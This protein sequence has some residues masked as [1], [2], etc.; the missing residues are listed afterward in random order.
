MEKL[1]AGVAVAAGVTAG[2]MTLGSESS[3]LSPLRKA[4]EKAIPGAFKWLNAE[5]KR[6]LWVLGAG[7]AVGIAGLLFLTPY[8]VVPVKISKQKRNLAYICHPSEIISMIGFKFFHTHPGIPKNISENSN[9]CYQKLV[10]TS[11]S[12]AAVILELHEELRE[13]VRFLF[14]SSR[15][16]QKQTQNNGMGFLFSVGAV[17]FLVSSCEQ[18]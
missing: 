5:P 2:V 1:F 18:T 10:Q 12:F 13:A 11:R 16:A 17:N 4:L 7:A 9:W 15:L 6:S 3:V 14:V 8:P